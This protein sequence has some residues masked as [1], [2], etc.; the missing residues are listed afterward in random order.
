MNASL[1][2]IFDLGDDRYIAQ[3]VPGVYPNERQPV[4]S[5]W[6]EED[7]EMYCGIY[8]TERIAG[9]DPLWELRSI[10]GHLGFIHEQ[11]A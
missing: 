2:T 11:D 6:S 5:N 3:V 10:D 9:L 1:S 4:V 8:T 7:R